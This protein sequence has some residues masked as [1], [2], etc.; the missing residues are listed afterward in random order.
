[1]RSVRQQSSALMRRG[2]LSARR[3]Q[4][5][6]TLVVLLFASIALLVLSRME[7]PAIS[8]VRWQLSELMTPLLAEASA[9]LVGLR[10]AGRTL[11]R[12]FDHAAEVERLKDENQQLKGWEWRAIEAE[13]KLSE[14]TALTGAV[15]DK[16]TAFV[17]SRVIANAA[18]P[19]VQSAMVNVGTMHA[20]KT[21]YPVLSGDGLVGRIV[22]TGETAAQ[23]L[24]LTDLN[25]RIPAHVGRHGARALVAGDNGPLPAL[26]YLGSD[27]D[28]AVGD[29][30]STSGVGGLFPR[31]LRIGT[32]VSDGAAFR[33]KPHADLDGLEYLSII[34]HETPTLGLIESTETVRGA[35]LRGGAVGMPRAKAGAP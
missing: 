8:H 20:V 10:R 34:F 2:V 19:F 13:R 9:P 11:V 1:M 24:L 35:V 32:V 21:G 29:E 6:L 23:V 14:L 3:P 25:S 22:E 30:V 31:G 33:V 26:T 28:I 17:T 18:G 4:F 15:K 5:R 7:H 16:A 12:V 27:A